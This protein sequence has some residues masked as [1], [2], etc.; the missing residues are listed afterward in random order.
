MEH[1]CEVECEICASKKRNTKLY[2]CVSCEAVCCGGCM[3]GSVCVDCAE[4]ED[5]YEK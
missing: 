2:K 3:S 4:G 1:K 5:N